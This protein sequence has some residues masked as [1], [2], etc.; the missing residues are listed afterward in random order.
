M[1]YFFSRDDDYSQDPIIHDALNK[2]L[3]E[4][5]P[6][7]RKAIYRV[8][9]DRV[10]EM[11]YILPFVE[12]PN[13]YVHSSDVKINAGLTSNTEIRPSHSMPEF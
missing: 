4:L 5:D 11:S 3:A 7:R 2:G 1:T 9:M 13:V 8:A 12:Q 10:N 6:E